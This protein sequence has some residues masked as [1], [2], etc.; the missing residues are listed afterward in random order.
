MK[1]RASCFES[2]SPSSSSEDES[3][4]MATPL[5]VATCTVEDP[6]IYDYDEYLEGKKEDQVATKTKDQKSKFAGKFLAAAQERRQNY[7]LIKQKQVEQERA[8]RIGV[9]AEL[10]DRAEPLV[11]PAQPIQP[12]Q[13]PTIVSLDKLV[14]K[15][16][17]SDKEYLKSQL[18][19]FDTKYD[20]KFLPT[21]LEI[22]NTLTETEIP[23][24]HSNS[25]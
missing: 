13:Q 10:L 11:T 5:P 12:S 20:S 16:S 4:S 24:K 7:D 22:V 2:E 17:E 14:A 18:R 8:K 23:S 9:Q 1:R 19:L 15:L 21:Y 3:T 6:S 25:N